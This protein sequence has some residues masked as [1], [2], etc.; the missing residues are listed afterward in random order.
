[1]K[2]SYR[3]G[4][5]SNTN[6]CLI[7]LSWRYLVLSLSLSGPFVT[8]E[9]SI[10][11]VVTGRGRNRLANIA[12]ILRGWLCVIPS[13]STEYQRLC[14]KACCLPTA[15]RSPCRDGRLRCCREVPS[16]LCQLC[17]KE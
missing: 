5:K 1:M 11:I 14:L 4:E 16:H 8:A 12:V 3:L 15:C 10:S 13:S 17:A 9:E 6:C 2:S 7:H